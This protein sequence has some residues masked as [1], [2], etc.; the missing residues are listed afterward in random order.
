M[1]ERGRAPLTGELT[2]VRRGAVELLRRWCGEDGDEV[3]GVVI[4]IKRRL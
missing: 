3:V 2:L 4:G 1:V